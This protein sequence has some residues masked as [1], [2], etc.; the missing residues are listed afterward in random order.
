MIEKKS[1]LFMLSRTVNMASC[2]WVIISP[3]MEPLTWRVGC[4]HPR[5]TS[6]TKMVYLGRGSRSGPS[7]VKWTK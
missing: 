7:S 5:L 4:Y 6:S 1:W 2:S 3:A